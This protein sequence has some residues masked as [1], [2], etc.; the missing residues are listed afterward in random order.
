M[1]NCHFYRQLQAIK[2]GGLAHGTLGIMGNQGTQNEIEC[3]NQ[4]T[5]PPDIGMQA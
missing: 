4:N 5:V 1:G 2:H 3:S